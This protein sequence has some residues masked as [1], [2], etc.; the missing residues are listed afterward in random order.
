MSV[1]LEQDRVLNALE[2]MGAKVSRRSLQRYAQQGVITP[3]EVYSYGRGV[4]R[5]SLYAPEAVVEAYAASR[6]VGRSLYPTRIEVPF[7]E[8]R[9]ALE[10]PQ[11]RLLASDI[12]SARMKAS[13]L[14][15]EQGTRGQAERRTVIPRYTVT[16]HTSGDDLLQLL[17]LSH[18]LRHYHEGWQRFN[19]WIDASPDYLAAGAEQIHR[20]VVSEIRELTVV[21]TTVG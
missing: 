9:L 6:L 19:A 13:K 11:K 17:V 5:V 12:R 1:S 21:D 10:L 14:L 7:P 20:R 4:G 8:L 16:R 15:D 2:H 18:W 3:P